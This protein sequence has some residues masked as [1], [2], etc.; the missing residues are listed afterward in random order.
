MTPDMPEF[1]REEY[2]HSYSHLTP[3]HVH[4]ETPRRMRNGLPGRSCPPRS[5]FHSRLGEGR[6]RSLFHAIPGICIIAMMLVPFRASM[7][8]EGVHIHLKDKAFV[9]PGEVFLKDIADINESD[10]VI[11]EGLNRIPLTSIKEFGTVV[12]LSRNQI[13]SA[14]M[15]RLAGSSGIQYSGAAIVQIRLKARPARYEE[16]ASVVKAYLSGETEW[17]PSE[18]NIPSIINLKEIELPEG[19]I[20]LRVSSLSPVPG[21]GKI[22]LPLEALQEG[23]V[24]TRFW[25]TAEVAVRAKILTAKSKIH[26]GTVITAA[27]IDLS[28]N[29][30]NDFMSAY[31]CNPEAVIGKVSQRV[32]SPGDPLTREAF[33]YPFLVNSGET[34]RLR[35]KRN[36]IELTSLVR[37]EQNGRLGQVIRVRNLDFS[38]TVKVLVTGRAEVEM[39]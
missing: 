2:Q 28:F 11:P 34:V 9:S 1:Y 37:A 19:E 17:R 16:I 8:S 35:L 6:I 3:F 25:V 15:D 39:Q 22:L 38:S 12:S 30:I 14:L 13:G 31:I 21:R 10:P 20:E 32:F 36:G 18:I 26:H 5:I 23:I 24:Q 29:E 33:A 27:D 7:G 4:R